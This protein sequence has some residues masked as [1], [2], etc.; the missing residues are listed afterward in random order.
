VSVWAIAKAGRPS[1]KIKVSKIFFTVI[2]F[3]SKN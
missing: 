1:V 2:L 3:L